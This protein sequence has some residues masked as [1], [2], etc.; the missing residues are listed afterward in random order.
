M[1]SA[2]A[3]LPQTS[4]A[5][6]QAAALTGPQLEFGLL[7]EEDVEGAVALVEAN[8]PERGG[9]LGPGSAAMLCR[10]ELLRRIRSDVHVNIVARA[11]AAADAPSSVVGLMFAI[12]GADTMSPVFK[13]LLDVYTFREGVDFSYGPVVVDAS[14][15]GQGVFDS[16][17]LK[18]GQHLPGRTAVFFINLKNQPSLAAHIKRGATRHHTFR[19]GDNEF[20]AATMQM[21]PAGPPSS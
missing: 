11:L 17:L 12:S 19:H 7:C 20:V 3:A 5:A 8:Q 15:R 16:M 18:L 10:K 1:D 13:A 14:L 21:G 4:A 6:S 9:A 2:G